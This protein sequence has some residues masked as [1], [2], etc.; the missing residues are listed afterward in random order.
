MAWKIDND[1]PVYLQ[2]MEHIKMQIATG[3][4]KA[5]DRVPPVSL[6]VFIRFTR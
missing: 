4:Y 5:G 3:E 6:P 2:L 1:R